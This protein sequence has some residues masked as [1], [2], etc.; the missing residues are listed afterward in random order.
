MQLGGSGGDG[1]NARLYQAPYATGYAGGDTVRFRVRVAWEN[2]VNV[3]AVKVV[4]FHYGAGFFG[5]NTGSAGAG[6][7]P[8]GAHEE[9][10]EGAMVLSSS[11][12][13]FQMKL[14]V[15]AGGPG[16]VSGTVR[17][18]DAELRRID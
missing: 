13:F 8:G 6:P 5:I 9:V 1:E 15:E 11:P 4:V 12:A 10:L 3:R 7:A 16:P 18:A 14:M 2:L 17:W